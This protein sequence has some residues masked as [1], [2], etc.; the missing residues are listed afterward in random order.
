MV[1]VKLF[2]GKHRL[3]GLLIIDPVQFVAEITFVKYGK[4]KNVAH[5]IYIKYQ[6]ISK[7]Q[8]RDAAHFGS[9]NKK[10]VWNEGC[11]LLLTADGSKITPRHNHWGQLLWRLY[12]ARQQED[13][14]R[15]G[16]NTRCSRSHLQTLSRL[17][18]WIKASADISNAGK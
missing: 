18:C 1:D 16:L 5:V 15:S 11:L 13:F 2:L 10:L 8:T 9:G 17:S 7:P 6:K 14:L 3:Y 4:W 12:V